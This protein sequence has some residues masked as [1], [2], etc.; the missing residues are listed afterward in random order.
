MQ[1]STTLSPDEKTQLQRRIDNLK[2][3]LAAQAVPI[4]VPTQTAPVVTAPLPPPMGAPPPPPPTSDERR[5]TVGPWI[6]TGIGGATAIAGVALYFVGGSKISSAEKGCTETGGV[7]MCSGA[8]GQTAA[9]SGS[10]GDTLKAAGEGM[11]W[12]GLAVAGGGLIWHF[13]EPTGSAKTDA[14]RASF[15]PVIAPGY[16]GAS[17]VGNF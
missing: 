9:S 16:S 13:L 7:Y 4:P 15:S 5:H 17:V 6:V 1:R 8:A 12:G 14:P 2:A 3:A 10:T 11:F